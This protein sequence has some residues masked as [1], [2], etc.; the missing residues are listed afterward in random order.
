MAAFASVSLDQAAFMR[1]RLRILLSRHYRLDQFD[2]FFAS[3]L[4]VARVLLSQLLL[5]QEQ[6][7]SQSRYAAFHP[8]S[9]LNV[10]PAFAVSAESLALIAH[11]DTAQ[12]QVRNLQACHKQGVTD[13]SESFATMQHGSLLNEATLFVTRLDRHADLASEM[14]MIALR[15]SDF[16]TLVRSKLRLFELGM[17]LTAPTEKA[18][19]RM[20]R[21]DWQPY[22][23]AVV[24]A[25]NLTKS[26]SLKSCHHP[27][28]PFACFPL[29]A[30]QRF[31]LARKT[32]AGLHL[33][34]PESTL[35]IHVCARGS[36]KKSD[37][38]T[39]NVNQRVAALLSD[40][41]LSEKLR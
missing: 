27:G 28:L 33:S 15:T 16:S 26:A 3:S 7:R 9:E 24:D 21:P 35:Q 23:V 2:L 6:M 22:N 31:Q 36:G 41:L 34:Q 18:L 38:M 40:H 5:K 10:P 12:G 32:E 29:T 8:I 25:I 4:Q 14:V 30:A 20:Q 17:A 13:A 39:Q 37:N 11:I 19:A 1:D